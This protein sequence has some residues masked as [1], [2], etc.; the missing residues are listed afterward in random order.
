MPVVRRIKLVVD[1]HHQIR[2]NIMP[3]LWIILLYTYLMR[4]M[5][6]KLQLKH[7][8]HAACCADE[9]QRDPTA[10]TM[11]FVIKFLE[12]ELCRLTDSKYVDPNLYDTT[13]I[14]L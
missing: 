13:D 14:A 1:Q 11:S 3:V 10:E 5:M 6:H 8:V 4:S 9:W 2:E 12:H 7:F